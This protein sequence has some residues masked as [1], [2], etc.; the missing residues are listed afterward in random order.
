MSPDIAKNP[1][2]NGAK[3]PTVEHHCLKQN[4]IISIE[5]VGQLQI[6]VNLHLFITLPYKYIINSKT[7]LGMC[8]CI[9]AIPEAFSHNCYLLCLHPC[10]NTVLNKTPHTQLSVTTFISP[11]FLFASFCNDPPPTRLTT[12]WLK[13]DTSLKNV[14]QKALLTVKKWFTMMKVQAAGLRWP[15]RELAPLPSLKSHQP[16]ATQ[17]LCL[18]GWRVMLCMSSDSWQ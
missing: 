6:K 16:V 17:S 10:C 5:L 7:T 8:L 15:G 4:P 13:H 3:L 14:F 18:Y 11:L 9:W 1:W 2:E 12:S